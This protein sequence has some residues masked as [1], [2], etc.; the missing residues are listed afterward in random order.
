MKQGSEYPPAIYLSDPPRLLILGI[1]R[2]VKEGR[3]HKVGTEAENR[4][5]FIELMDQ[6]FISLHSIQQKNAFPLWSRGER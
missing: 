4:Q 2:S 3:I 5:Y 6:T 1:G